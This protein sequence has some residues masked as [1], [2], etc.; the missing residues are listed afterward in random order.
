MLCLLCSR[1]KEQT[2]V[3]WPYA[4][5][6]AAVAEVSDFPSVTARLPTGDYSCALRLVLH[7]SLTEL[8]V[9]MLT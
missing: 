6:A 4:G 2:S 7:V 8:H 3:R 9:S 5:G 1:L